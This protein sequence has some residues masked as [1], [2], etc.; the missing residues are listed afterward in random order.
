MGKKTI[1]IEISGDNKAGK[2][3]IA[4]LIEHFLKMY[5]YEV[6]IKPESRNELL[7]SILQQLSSNETNNRRVI[8]IDKE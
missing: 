5:H 7:V 3:S 2:S 4:A 6:E 8:I 1:T